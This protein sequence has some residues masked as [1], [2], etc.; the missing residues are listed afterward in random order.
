MTGVAQESTGQQDLRTYLGIFWR[1]KLLFLTFV[2]LIPL[3]VYV[4]E[5]SKPKVYRSTS[6]VEVQDVSTG[7]ASSGTSVPGNLAAVARL[8][9]TTPVVDTAAR[10]LHQPPS[11][12][13]DISATADT[14]TGFVTIAARNRDPGRAAAIANALAAALVRRQADQA[15]HLIGQQ[16]TALR[17][18]LAATPRSNPGQRVTLLQQIGQLRALAA[19][20]ASGGQV[21]QAATPSATPV[22]PRIGRAVG[23]A[24]V[25]GLLLGVGAVL[26]AEKADRRLR[27]PEDIE[28]L[29]SWP[30][31]AAIPPSAFSPDH[32][33]D[34]RALESF[35]MLRAGLTYFNVE[36]PLGSVA[37]ISPVAGDGKT[38]VA[39]GLA[40]AVARAGKRAILVDADLRNP[41]VCVRLGLADGG[42]GL[43]DVLAGERKPA[44]VMLRYPMDSPDGGRLLVVP[45]GRPPP[46][47][48]ALLGSQRMRTLVGQLEG[49]ADL[50]IYDSVAALAVSDSLPLLQAVSGSVV[51]LRMNRSSRAPVRRLQTMIASARGTVLGVVATGSRSLAGGYGAYY[52]E[53]GH[54]GG[55]LGLL[56]LRRR[57]SS[58]PIDARSANGGAAVG[59]IASP[60][61]QASA[62]AEQSGAA[63]EP[64]D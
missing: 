27:T 61:D 49:E 1:W 31:L 42:A 51:V 15:T 4:V 17:K 52:A 45:A 8:A 38:T 11:S 35:Q 22:E 13:R 33:T 12:L 34:P 41:Q 2:V 6:L 59:D 60:P 62:G 19:S 53:D 10:L 55:A 18:Q 30:V 32:L 50:V 9:T 48:A 58:M 25:I 57:R 56:H 37:I 46:N 23:L 28:S 21:V 20:S 40:V 36:R 7:L 63:D 29:T 5:R 47:P 16:V 14:E 39:V 24:A 64:R 54:H 43:G 3:A 44:D 26:V